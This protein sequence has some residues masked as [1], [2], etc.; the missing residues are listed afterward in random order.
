MTE[1]EYFLVRKMEAFH[2]ER[3]EDAI[4]RFRESLKYTSGCYGEIEMYNGKN[5]WFWIAGKLYCISFRQ[6]QI[7]Y[8]PNISG[9]WYFE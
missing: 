2:G 9:Y 1:Q 7:A 8:S 3:R 4:E 5:N 6:A